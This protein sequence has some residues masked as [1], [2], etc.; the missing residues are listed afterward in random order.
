VIGV[1]V[2]VVLLSIFLGVLFGSIIPSIV[3]SRVGGSTLQFTSMYISNAGNTSF[4]LSGNGVIS[5]A[6]S[7]ASDIMATNL[8]VSYMGTP[9]GTL[10]LQEINVNGGVPT[11]ISLSTDFQIT[12]GPTFDQFGSDLIQGTST[13][14]HLSGSPDVEALGLTFKNVDFE[15]DIPLIGF[16]GFQDHPVQIVKTDVIAGAAGLL[17]LLLEIQLYNPSSVEMELGNTTFYLYFQDTYIG[18]TTFYAILRYGLNNFTLTA[19]YY[20]PAPYNAPPGEPGRTFLSRFLTGYTNVI[21]MT[22]SPNY[23]NVLQKS[24]MALKAQTGVPGLQQPLL[25]KS[26]ITLGVFE[27][28]TS[29]R[30]INPFS[31]DFVLECLN[32]NIVQND[33]LSAVGQISN[34]CFSTPVLVGAMQTIDSP[35][36]P[37][38]DVATLIVPYAVDVSGWFTVSIPGEG[39]FRQQIDYQASNVRSCLYC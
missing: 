4:H 34:Y 8:A 15:K 22:G 24:L 18:N 31:V 33:T 23:G 19:N 36:I 5:N 7:D 35:G 20:Q 38:S 13:S 27:L 10:P 26:S 16:N 6:G 2:A 21:T 32:F 17:V 1:V 25:L 29:V 9:M 28:L 11:P 12:N 14:W 39:G 37:L 3:Q 30:M